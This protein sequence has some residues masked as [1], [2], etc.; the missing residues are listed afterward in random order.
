MERIAWQYWDG[1]S[2]V[3][4]NVADKTGGFSYSGRVT[5]IV[6]EGARASD[7]WIATVL[8]PGSLAGQFKGKHRSLAKLLI[9][10]G[11]RPSATFPRTPCESA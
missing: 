2:W 9:S 6:P 10:C 11:C 3:T 4:F 8:A 5:F 7:E 1:N